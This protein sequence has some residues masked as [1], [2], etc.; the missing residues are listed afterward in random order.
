MSPIRSIF[1]WSSSK[2]LWIYLSVT[3]LLLWP[4]RLCTSFRSKVFLKS[5][6]ANVDLSLC[7]LTCIPDALD[8][9]LSTV[10]ESRWGRVPLEVISKGLSSVP[11]GTEVRKASHRSSSCC[12]GREMG[13]VRDFPPFPCQTVIFR[14]FMSTCDR[15]SR[16]ISLRRSPAYRPRHTAILSHPLACFSIRRTSDGL[17]GSCGWLRGCRILFRFRI[18]HIKLCS[19]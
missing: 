19:G 8:S 6:V 9:P 11:S 16:R 18:L 13:M 2:L 17:Y 1:C 10:P 5:W 14:F 15:S 7:Q 3:T 4:K 12:N